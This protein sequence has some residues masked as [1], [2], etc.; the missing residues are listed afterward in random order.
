[1]RVCQDG[2]FIIYMKVS[3]VASFCV[4]LIKVMSVPIGHICSDLAVLSRH[5]TSEWML[6][7]YLE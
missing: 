5:K 1:M 2:V 4:K 3:N 7:D 6:T